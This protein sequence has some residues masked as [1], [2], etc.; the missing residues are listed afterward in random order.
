MNSRNQG[1]QEWGLLK[2]LAV[3]TLCGVALGCGFVTL[4]LLTDM[5]GIATLI[6]QADAWVEASVLLF[7]FFSVTFG[8]LVAGTAVMGKKD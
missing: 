2:F 3:H 8:S 7:V 6:S 4:I 1:Q 5:F